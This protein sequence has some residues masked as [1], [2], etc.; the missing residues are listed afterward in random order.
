[1][2]PN[3]LLG[4]ISPGVHQWLSLDSEQAY[5]RNPHPT[6]GPGS[7]VYRIN[8]HGYRTYEFDQASEVNRDRLNVVCVGSSGAFGIGIPDD[9][10]FLNLFAEHLSRHTGRAVVTWNLSQGGTGADY[11]TRMLFSAIPVLKPHVLL[12]TCFPLNRREFI[13]EEGRIFASYAQP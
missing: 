2:P 12:L 5:R 13:G 4:Y 8:R 7:I 11:V 6:L 9:K 10:L 1:M 3:P